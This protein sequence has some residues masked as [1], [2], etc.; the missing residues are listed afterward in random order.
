MRSQPKVIPLTNLINKAFLID[1][2]QKTQV[3]IDLQKVKLSVGFAVEKCNERKVLAVL[4]GIS[5]PASLKIVWALNIVLVCIY[6]K[7]R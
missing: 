6:G 2:R 3:S 7:Q 5:L 4:I 1:I